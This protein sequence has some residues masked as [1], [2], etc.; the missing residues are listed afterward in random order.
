MVAPKVEIFFFKQKMHKNDRHM[1]DVQISVSEHENKLI[2]NPL[3]VENVSF[4]SIRNIF[5]DDVH[6]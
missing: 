3:P 1:A 6:L 2:G 4:T 5:D